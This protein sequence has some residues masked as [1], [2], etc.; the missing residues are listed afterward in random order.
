MQVSQHWLC[1][2]WD[3]IVLFWSRL[4][5]ALNGAEQQPRP[6]LPYTVCQPGS[7]SAHR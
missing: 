6:P 2:P 4:S 3:Q 1:C 7:V 5:C